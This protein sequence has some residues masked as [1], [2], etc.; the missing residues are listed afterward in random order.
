MF[1]NNLGLVGVIDFGK[2]WE[3]SQVVLVTEL[4]L[5]KTVYKSK[6]IRWIDFQEAFDVLSGV[7]TLGVMEEDENRFVS[8]YDIAQVVESDLHDSG[9]SLGN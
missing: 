4:N 9:L 8:G 1:I 3:L 2:D 6:F 7:G 5:P